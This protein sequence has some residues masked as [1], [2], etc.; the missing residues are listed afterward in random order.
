MTI[1]YYEEEKIAEIF[2]GRKIVAVEEGSFSLGERYWEAASGRL[3]L[4][5][6]TQVYVIPNEGGCSCGAGDYSLKKLATADNIITS[7]KVE[8]E[9][10][11]VT[12]YYEP[13]ET[14]YRIF[15][16]MEDIQISAVEIQG[17]DGNGYYGTWFSLVVV[18]VGL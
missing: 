13:E 10:L 4:D 2:L 1:Y 5:N 15:V 7:V 17:D 8:R 12:E 18:P 9:D 6:G 14:F 16:Y 3:T 11:N